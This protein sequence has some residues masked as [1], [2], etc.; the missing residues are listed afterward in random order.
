M[1]RGLREVILRIKYIFEIPPGE[2]LRIF[3]LSCVIY[4]SS[5]W[6][7]IKRAFSLSL[8]V[9]LCHSSSFLFTMRE[10]AYIVC[11]VACNAGSIVREREGALPSG[12][13][14]FGLPTDR[15]L[16]A[17]SDGRMRTKQTVHFFA[18][19]APEDRFEYGQKNG[20][21]FFAW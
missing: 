16:S 14:W 18:S 13:L 20:D 4:G 15:L 8:Q 9:P 11:L 12:I 10:N 3:A 19:F 2:E 6:G 21:F 1:G 7:I 5:N 17:V